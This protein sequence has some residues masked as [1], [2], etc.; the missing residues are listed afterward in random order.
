MLGRSAT[1]KGLIGALIVLLSFAVVGL[2]D[3]R[4][5]RR[6]EEGTI[7]GASEEANRLNVVETG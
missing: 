2:E 5:E 1:T 4:I 7:S 3:L 6:G